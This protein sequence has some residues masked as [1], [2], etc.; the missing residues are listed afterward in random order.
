MKA[1]RALTDEYCITTYFGML[2]TKAE[3]AL[4]GCKHCSRSTLNNVADMFFRI[5]CVPPYEIWKEKRPKIGLLHKLRSNYSLSHGFHVECLR[6]QERK[7]KT[8]LA[9]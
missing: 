9:G 5:E 8:F 7:P 6:P 2:M 3:P 1:R 4:S